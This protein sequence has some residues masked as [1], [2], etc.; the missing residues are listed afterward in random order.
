MDILPTIIFGLSFLSLISGVVLSCCFD[1]LRLLVEKILGN[2]RKIF[3][4]TIDF[5]FAIFFTVAF[6]LILYYGNKGLFRGLYLISLVLGI[7]IYFTAFFKIFRKILYIVSAPIIFAIKIFW[8][9]TIK[10]YVFLNDTIEK[11][12]FRLYNKNENCKS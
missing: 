3:I 11:I 12:L 9:I 5:I 1:L 4:F 6:I 8:K 2:K 7:Y 10:I